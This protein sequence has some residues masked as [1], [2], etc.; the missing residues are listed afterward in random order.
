MEKMKKIKQ[1]LSIIDVIID[2]YTIREL[3]LLSSQILSEHDATNNFIKQFKSEHDS[4][5]FY[6]NVIKWYIKKY[7]KLPNEKY[8]V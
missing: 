2:D 7:N 3:Q 8:D 5:Q 4:H 1:N 6:K